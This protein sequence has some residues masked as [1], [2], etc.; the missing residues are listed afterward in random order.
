MTK[1][2]KL[3]FFLIGTSNAFA[4]Y[5]FEKYKALPYKTYNDWETTLNPKD[6]LPMLRTIHL[7]DFDAIKS[8]FKI[9][10][11]LKLTEPDS[12]E[13][14]ELTLFKNGEKLEEFVVDTRTISNPLPVLVADVN[15]DGLNDIKIIFPNYGCGAFNYY[16]ETVYLFQKK[17]GNFKAIIYTDLFEEFENR[18]ERDLNN[19]GNFEIITQTFQNFGKHN[20]WLFNL[21]NYKDGQLKNVNSIANYP[22]MIPLNSF[23]ISKKISRKTMKRYAIK[24]P[25]LN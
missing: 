19:D 2:L 4:Q 9:V 18:P 25:T 10:Q 14:S 16:C 23:E 7:A 1:L 11:E 13:Y 12:I 22:I 8:T 24:S 5:P 17:D 6:S 3:I 20:Y 15:G 21:Y